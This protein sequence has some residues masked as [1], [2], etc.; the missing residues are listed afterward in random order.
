MGR[1][2]APSSTQRIKNYK[3]IGNPDIISKRDDFAIPIRP[4]RTLKDTVSFYFGT[5]SLMLYNI[6]TGHR[7]MEKTNQRAIIY[8]RSSIQKVMDAGRDF[9]FTDGQA[10][11]VGLTRYFDD[12][13][14]LTHVDM[15]AVHT[16]DFDGE[17]VARDR[18]LLRKKQA[19]FHV[20]EFLPCSAID[21]IIVKDDNVQS[22][23]VEIIEENDFKDIE[24]LVDNNAYFT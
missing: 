5:R 16:R 14:D 2:D 19:E 20:L 3:P 10:N 8:L 18:D 9:F 11:K 1:I 13:A 7:G 12:S 6:H 21:A 15:A 23:V 24:V 17:A 22:R 4:D